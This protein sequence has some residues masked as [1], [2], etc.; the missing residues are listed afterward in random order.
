MFPG[1]L[2]DFANP[3]DV[4]FR[5]PREI[6]SGHRPVLHDEGHEKRHRRHRNIR[7]RCPCY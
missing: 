5:R 6:K 4:G 7:R 1:E 3:E 2:P